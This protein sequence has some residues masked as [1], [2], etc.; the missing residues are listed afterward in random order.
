[1]SCDQTNRF[2]AIFVQACTVKF[3]RLYEYFFAKIVIMALEKITQ[4]DFVPKA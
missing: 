3:Y 1:M 2:A 4:A